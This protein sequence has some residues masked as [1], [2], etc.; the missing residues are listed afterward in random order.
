MNILL[1]G[2]LSPMVWG[3]VE[4]L[5]R[6]AHHVTMLGQ[7]GGLKPEH[8][9]AVFHDMH[10]GN[11]DAQKLLQAGRFHVIVFFYACQCEDTKEYGSVQG[12][13]L[14]VLFQFQQTASQCGV[15]RFILITD[16]RVF[17][18]LQEA[19]E[20]ETPIPDSPTGILIKAAEDCLRY[21]KADRMKT[22]IVRVTSLYMQGAEDAF[23]SRALHHAR[24]NKPMVIDGTEDS[25]CDFLHADDLALFLSLSLEA[26]IS[27]AACLAKRCPWLSW[28]YSAGWPNGFLPCPGCSRPSALQI[29]GFSM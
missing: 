8:T 5:G 11:P 26:D 16:Q 20:N 13:M 21:S 1:T 7:A 4:R 12:S 24:N 25:P 9:S 28:L 3:M 22:L 19:R 23:F 15:E 18:S 14:D 10:P 17:G 29:S 2:I 6:D 27:G